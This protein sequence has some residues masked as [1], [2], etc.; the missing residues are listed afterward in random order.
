MVG[1]HTLMRRILDFLQ[2]AL[3][4]GSVNLVSVSVLGECNSPDRYLSLLGTIHPHLR[5]P[6]SVDIKPSPLPPMVAL[7][8]EDH[9]G[10]SRY[11]QHPD[12]TEP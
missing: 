9:V 4:K 1:V 11:S 10:D 8:Q 6:L 2:R 7:L 3:R 5:W 12:D